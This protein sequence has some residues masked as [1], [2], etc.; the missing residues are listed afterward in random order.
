MG[1]LLPTRLNLGMLL[2]PGNTGQSFIMYTTYTTLLHNKLLLHY[3]GSG[4]NDLAWSL[5]PAAMMGTGG[6]KDGDG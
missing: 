2:V 4:R 3:T 5:L 1:L 6:S